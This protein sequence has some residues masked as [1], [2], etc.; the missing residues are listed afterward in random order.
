MKFNFTTFKSTKL[1]LK[2]IIPINAN[3]VKKISNF[4][5]WTAAHAAWISMAISPLALG[6]EAE[7]ISQKNFQTYIDEAGLNKKTTLGEFFE[8][9]KFYYPASV[10][11]DLKDYVDKNKNMVMQPVKVTSAQATNGEQIPVLTFTD[12]KGKTFSF[13]IFGEK[14]NWAKYNNITFPESDFENISHFFS[15]L[16]SSDI[17][18]RKEGDKLIQEQ[19]KNSAAKSTTNSNAVAMSQAATKGTSTGTS[20]AVGNEAYKKDFARF[21]GFPR[22]TPIMWKTLSLKEKAEYI[23]QMRLL[24]LNA[25]KVLEAA[26]QLDPE[27]QGNAPTSQNLTPDQLI[28]DKALEQIQKQQ[29]SIENFYRIIFGQEVSADEGKTKAASKPMEKAG[30]KGGAAPRKKGSGGARPDAAKGSAPDVDPAVA[31]Q[32]KTATVSSET[33]VAVTDSQRKSDILNASN[34]V[35]AGY[36][37]SYQ[38]KSGKS[39]CYAED[40][41]LKY[42]DTKEHPNLQFVVKANEECKKENN[43]ASFIACNPI[44]YSYKSNGSPVCVDTTNKNFQIATHFEGP[45]DTQSPLNSKNLKD[46][47]IFAD[48]SNI[49]PEAKRIQMIEEDQKNQQYK[50]SKD[51]LTGYLAHLDK[52]KSDNSSNLSKLFSDGKWSKDLD[53]QLVQIQANFEG[54]IRRATSSC[55]AGWKN[56]KTKHEKNQKDAC[57]QLHRRWLFTEVFIAKI[58]QQ[59]C[60][61]KSKYIGSYDNNELVSQASEDKSKLNKNKLNSNAPV[62]RCDAIPNN[63]RPTPTPQNTYSNAISDVVIGIGQKCPSNE[64]AMPTPEPEKPGV[65][66]KGTTAVGLG[67]KTNCKCESSDKLIPAKEIFILLQDSPISTVCPVSCPYASEDPQ[68]DK[69]T[70]QCREGEFKQDETGKW[71]CKKSNLLLLGGVI[72]GFGAFFLYLK[73]R[74]KGGKIPTPPVPPVPN[75]C[76]KCTNPKEVCGADCKCV[77]IKPDLRCLPPMT[78]MMPNCMCDVSA[79]KCTTGQEIDVPACNC[80][81]KVDIILTC[82][83]GKPM[84]DANWDKNCD[85]CSDGSFKT[86]PIF[87]RMN[88]C[89][90]VPPASEGGKGDKNCGNKPCAGGVPGKQ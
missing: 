27:A 20:S 82:P 69:S 52:D 53:D 13:Q 75:P 41:I 70:C 50:L 56:P 8:K 64:I 26:G 14:D 30:G 15:R 55:I 46:K 3:A 21:E 4:T 28:D 88:G 63:Q 37:S 81:P 59:G 40:A 36:I 39:A 12:P 54:E 7:A 80:K 58:R 78:G 67:D 61:P 18:L 31:A 17:R 10:Y 43:S 86:R 6:K 25:R 42:N 90:D 1:N 79:V 16:Q 60:D 47:L 24:W 65:C 77:P 35:V 48:Y 38:R 74:H 73:N 62:C 33:P 84:P 83:N 29:S 32:I 89:P 45:C 76:P 19:L 71:I 44:L 66:P 85:K 2:T 57:D 22:I 11:N 5:S 72:A 34:C 68:F 9:T 87:G 51:F 23:V 49:T